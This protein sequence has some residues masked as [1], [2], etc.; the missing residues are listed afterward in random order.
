M[1]FDKDLLSFYLRN[2]ANQPVGSTKRYNKCPNCG[3]VSRHGFIVT[4]KPSGV[5]CWCHACHFKS[6]KSNT[7]APS[8]STCLLTARNLRNKVN[9]RFNQ[10]NAASGETVEYFRKKANL[11]LDLT[12]E[13][14][15]VARCW[16]SLYGVTDKEINEFGFCWSQRLSRLI[17][18]VKDKLGRV[19]FW[20]GRY[21]GPDGTKNPKYINTTCSKRQA[22]FEVGNPKSG[23][24]V[25]VEDILSALAVARG[26]KYRALAL[27]GSFVSDEVI[28]KLLS[29]GRQVCVWLDLDKMCENLAFTKRLNVFGIPACSIVT[30]KDPKCY[31]PS[32]IQREVS[33]ALSH[34]IFHQ[35]ASYGTV[36][37]EFLP[38]YQQAQEILQQGWQ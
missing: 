28:L 8:F 10:T 22:W 4:V 37:Q 31:K 23:V 27:L 29:E 35:K 15:A 18:P 2:E 14:P 34:G 24:I 30:N 11:P 13:L 5:V 3:R 19:V 6:G 17:L 21:F 20:Q 25:L 32:F 12:S 9:K 7:G 38:K 26:G 33:H 36:H 1:V 16:L